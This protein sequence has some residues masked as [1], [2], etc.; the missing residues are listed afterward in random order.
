MNIFVTDPCPIKSAKF[1]DNKRVVKMVLES[2]QMLSSAV[3]FYGGT[4]PYKATHV[5]HP[6]NVWVRTSR[7][8]YLWLYAHFKALL[9]EYTLRYGRVHK[10]S[11]IADLLL[12]EAIYIPIGGATPFVNCAANKDKG[13]DYKNVSDTFMAYKLYLNDRWDTDKV[14]PAWN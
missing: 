8:N 2:A 1:L 6:C 14:A 9:A 5:N 7:S 4:G 12:S 13:V 10:C 11:Q 3:H